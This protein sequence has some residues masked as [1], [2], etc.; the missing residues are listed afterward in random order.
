MDQ[1][2][3]IDVGMWCGLSNQNA[4]F[5]QATAIGSEMDRVHQN[6]FRRS[7]KWILEERTISFAKISS[8]EYDVTSGICLATRGIKLYNN[9]V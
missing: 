9:K 2:F 7:V 1:P 8:Y 4:P 6:L 5:S 3:T